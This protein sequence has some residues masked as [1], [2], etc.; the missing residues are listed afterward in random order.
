MAFGL[1]KDDSKSDMIGA[2]AVVAWVDHKTGKGNA[3]DYYLASKE[4][5]R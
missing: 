2:D 5:V 3:V 1:G 4:Q